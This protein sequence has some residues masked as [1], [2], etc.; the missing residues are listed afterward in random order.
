MAV[1]LLCVNVATAGPLVCIWLEWRERHD[2]VAGRLGRFL[3]W[4][5]F[6]L[7]LV[8]GGLGVLVGVAVWGDGFRVALRLLS[9]KLQFGVWEYLFS[10]VLMLAHAI[11]W[12]RAPQAGDAVRGVRMLLAVLAGSNLL[13]HFPF[14]FVVLSNIANGG[15]TATEHVNH[16]TFRSLMASGDV[17]PRSVHFGLA[18]FAVTGVTL[19]LYLAR[20]RRKG[21]IEASEGQALGA[22]CA[23]MALTPTL[24]QILVG[25]W[26]AMKLPAAG[27]K[28]IM[29]QDMVATATFLL[30][31][32]LAFWLMHLLAS[33][34]LREQ[35][36]SK[37]NKAALV[38]ALV[39]ALMSVALVR[40]KRATAVGFEPPVVQSAG[41]TND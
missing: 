27:M 24:A 14:L 40:I 17:L 35:T 1:H 30:S 20:M 23:R 41:E 10:V 32:L 6:A 12:S 19:L 3:A 36:Q 4:K 16:S 18:C 29:G 22:A 37:V 9:Y 26:L 11:W 28:A 31:V 21:Q 33:L 2:P 5:S 39:V 13:Y 15:I 38:M 7:L 34:A 25:M 8:G